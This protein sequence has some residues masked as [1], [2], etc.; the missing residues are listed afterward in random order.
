MAND[1]E[2]EIEEMIDKNSLEKVLRT[3]EDIC[4]GKAEH[5]RENWQD[6]KAAKLWD[7]SGKRVGSAA[8]SLTVYP[9]IK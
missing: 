2:Y 3:I 6:P 8:A 1:L 7:N 9:G 5:L 4:Y